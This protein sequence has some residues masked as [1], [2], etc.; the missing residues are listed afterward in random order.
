MCI[1]GGRATPPELAPLPRSELTVPDRTGTLASVFPGVDCTR[2]SRKGGVH[3]L[4]DLTS[5]EGATSFWGTGVGV[6][7]GGRLLCLCGVFCLLLVLCCLWWLVAD[8]RER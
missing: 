7:V 4:P 1:S 3:K 8:S 6:G 2:S 5:I